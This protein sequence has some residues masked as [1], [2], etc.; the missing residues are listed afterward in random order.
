MPFFKLFILSFIGIMTISGSA[1]ESDTLNYLF[2]GHIKKKT[3][4]K[5]DIDP[6]VK[7]L[8]LSSYDRL[9]LGGDVTDESNQDYSTLMYIDSIFD[10]SNPSNHWAFGNHDLRNY[11]TDWLREITNKDSYYTYFENGITTMVINYA[12]PPTDCESLNDQFKM[13]QAVCDSIQES[14]HLIIISHNCVWGNVPELPP[15]GLYAHANLKYWLSNCYDKPADYLSSI[16][17]LLLQVKDKYIEVINILGDT[18]AYSKGRS[19]MSLDGIHFIA[20]GI[21]ASTQELRGPDKVLIFNHHPE[22]SY[23]NWQFHNLDSLYQSFQ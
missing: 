3:N 15:P 19:M 21:K 16:Y 1:Q 2:L 7:G 11:N 9:W 8:D 4:G 20:S 13:I 6:R 23:L 10:V 14:S 22:S 5:N 17:P 18:G 12:I